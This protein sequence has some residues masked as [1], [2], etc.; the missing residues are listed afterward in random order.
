MNEILTSTL[1][2]YLFTHGSAY[3][4]GMIIHGSKMQLD[5]YPFLTPSGMHSY[6][7]SWACVIFWYA[8]YFITTPLFAIGTLIYCLFDKDC[9]LLRKPM[10][11]NCCGKRI[12]QGEEY[13]DPYHKYNSCCS[14]ACYAVKL[15][16]DE[17]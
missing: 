11:C 1:V 10:H 15:L 9:R 4:I 3:I 7:M 16:E 13:Y 2:A 12:K 5:D 14:V 8:V 6:G 17:E